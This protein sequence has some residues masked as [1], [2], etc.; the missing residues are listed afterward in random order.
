M[1][2]HHRKKPVICLQLAVA[3]PGQI[4]QQSSTIKNGCFWLPPQ[5]TLD[6]RVLAYLMHGRRGSRALARWRL[7]CASLLTTASRFGHGTRPLPTNPETGTGKSWPRQPR[8]ST[9]LGSEELKRDCHRSVSVRLLLG[10]RDVCDD[11]VRARLFGGGTDHQGGRTPS[12]CNLSG[13]LLGLFSAV[14]CPTLSWPTGD[15][16]VHKV[17][18]GPPTG[19]IYQA[20]GVMK[21]GGDAI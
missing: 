1:E 20:P 3:G 2:A 15:L 9:D 13:F 4:L 17:D 6:G 12:T 21:F 10:L 14:L 19:P 5:G 16:L 18:M 7:R 8:D 11:L